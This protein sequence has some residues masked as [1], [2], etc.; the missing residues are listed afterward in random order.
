M[1]TALDDV[2]PERAFAP[3]SNVAPSAALLSN[4]PLALHPRVS[5]LDHDL[6]GAILTFYSHL[7]SGYRRFLFFIDQ[8]PFFNAPS[9]L[10]SKTGAAAGPD[11]LFY[12][13]FL[14]SRAFAAFLEDGA[15]PFTDFIATESRHHLEALFAAETHPLD[16]VRVS[17]P[18]PD[19]NAD[20]HCRDPKL[21]VTLRL[22]VALSLALQ[23]TQAAPSSRNLLKVPLATVGKFTNEKFYSS[24]V[25]GLNRRVTQL[26]RTRAL[27]F[28]CSSSARGTLTTILNRR[29]RSSHSG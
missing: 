15:S 19:L 27:R 8:V 23:Y 5:T 18:T 10:A 12:D 22:P 25:I 4:A 21:A 16:L 7:L 29:T 1:Q 14:D 26:Q 2:L 11:K 24:S 28:P 13:Q 9:F 6:Y 17:P 3:E 20:E